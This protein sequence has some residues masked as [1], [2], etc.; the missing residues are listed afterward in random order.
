[1]NT[2]IKKL[3]IYGLT[4]GIAE[5]VMKAT[6]NKVVLW[7]VK[8]VQESAQLLLKTTNVKINDTKI[9]QIERNVTKFFTI[10]HIDILD[11]L[12][13]V[14]CGYCDFVENSKKP[15]KLYN[16]IIKR[17]MWLISIFDPQLNKPHIYDNA[18]DNY[19]RWCA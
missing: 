11:S 12:C 7:R 13:F 5:T 3:F 6:D 17:V 15:T 16:S 14:L 2:P 1:M 19:E 18:K 4:V 9:R 8:K 10:D